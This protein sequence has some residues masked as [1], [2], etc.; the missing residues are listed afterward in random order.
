MV[1]ILALRALALKARHESSEAL[2]A[3]E[4]ALALAESEGYVRLFLDERVPMETLLSEFIN[5]RPKGPHDARRHAVFGTRGG[6]WRRSN[7]HIQAPM[8]QVTSQGS[9]DRRSIPS[10]LVKGRYSC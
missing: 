1:E 9:I 6:C 8:L 5:G 7:H 3:L 2:A 4:R 10:P